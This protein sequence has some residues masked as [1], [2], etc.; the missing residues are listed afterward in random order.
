MLSIRDENVSFPSLA[1]KTPGRSQRRALGDISNRTGGGG[2]PAKST[3]STRKTPAPVVIKP[4]VK[5]NVNFQLPVTKPVSPPERPAGRTWKE[6]QNLEHDN[7]NNYYNDD[8]DSLLEDL[9]ESFQSY[10]RNW[11]LQRQEVRLE[12]GR[13]LETEYEDELQGRFDQMQGTSKEHNVLCV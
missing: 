13:R 9:K 2:L 11:V 6:Q 3:L 1:G 7:S 10:R 4:T 5:R 12:H 8:D